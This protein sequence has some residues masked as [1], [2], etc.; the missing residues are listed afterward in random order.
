M[1]NIYRIIWSDEALSNLKGII[2]YLENNWTEKEI[3]KFALLLEHQLDFI[4]KNP[5]MFSFFKRGKKI[6]K[7]V[8]TKQVSI[9]YRIE[10][11][12]IQI[13]TLFDNRQSPNKLKKL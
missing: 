11:E 13:V 3:R 7:A 1:Q 5:L 10:N 12:D 2:T 4:K 9:F 6:R 8:L